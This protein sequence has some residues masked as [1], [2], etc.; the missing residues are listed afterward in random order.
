[1]DSWSP[2]DGVGIRR[3]QERLAKGVGAPLPTFVG[4]TATSP[5]ITSLLM[6]AT[7]WGEGELISSRGHSPD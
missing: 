7:E 6:K 3:F 5:T 1:M 4:Q 2:P